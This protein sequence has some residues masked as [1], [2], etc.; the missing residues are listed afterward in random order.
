M[1]REVAKVSNE[2]PSVKPPLQAVPA[3]RLF[4]LG[5][6]AKTAELPAE[7]EGLLSQI[8]T[9]MLDSDTVRLELRAYAQGNA[10]TAREAR[11]LSLARGL[12][13][14]EQ[15]A[16]HGVR[17]ARVDIR[18]LGISATEGPLD[19]VDLVLIY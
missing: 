11:R 13:I 1:Q 15:L 14:R 7:A 19:R 4:S 18:A 12:A 3:D 9:R 5:F 17:S 6:A 16:A 2:V 8:A 10:D